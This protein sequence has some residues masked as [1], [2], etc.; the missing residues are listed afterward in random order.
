MRAVILAGGRGAR[1]APYTTVIPK[2]LLPLGERPI[3]DLVLNQLAADGFTRATLTLGYMADYFKV[4]LAQRPQLREQIDIDFIEEAEP[5]GTAGSLAEVPGLDEPFLVMNGD[6]FTDLDYAALYRYHCEQDSWLT[7]AAHQK[8]VKIDLGVLETDA[9]GAL[10]DYIEKPTKEY[11]VSMGIYIYSPQVLQ[12][13]PRGQ[14]LDF[15]TL[16]MQLKNAGRKVLTWKTDATWLDLG[17]PEDLQQ[18]TEMFIQQEAQFM[19][20]L[21]TEPEPVAA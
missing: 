1:L 19:P 17:R 8:Q 18:A 16:A 12:M 11:S 6:I 13:I 5:T 15:P 4:F 10:V 7:I 21:V 9:S 14:Y 2:P 20:R 3:L